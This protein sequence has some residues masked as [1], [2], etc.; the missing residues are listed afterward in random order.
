MNDVVLSCV[1]ESKNQ[2]K[3]TLLATGAHDQVV[4]CGIFGKLV[5]GTEL[6]NKEVHELFGVSQDT[7]V[8]TEPSNA[9]VKGISAIYEINESM[10]IAQF[11][12]NIYIRNIT[13]GGNEVVVPL[14]GEPPFALILPIDF[15]YPAEKISIVNAYTTFRNWVNNSNNYGNWPEFYDSSKIYINPNNR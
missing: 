14:K 6:N 5:S 1:R 8:N 7:F 3:L 9:L 4:I 13:N 2:V 10:T 12:G 15:N 11:L